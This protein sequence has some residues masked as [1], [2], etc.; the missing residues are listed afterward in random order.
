[1]H[2]RNI[3]ANFDFAQIFLDIIAIIFGY[4]ISVLIYNAFIKGYTVLQSQE[5]V[6][7][8]VVFAVIFVLSMLLLRMY[9]VTTFYY[10]DRIVKRT[11]TSAAIAGMNLSLIV[12]M[13]KIDNMSRL[14]FVMFCVISCMVV[15]TERIVLRLCKGKI[16]NGYTHILF[17]GDNDTLERYVSFVDK[18]AIKMKIDRFVNYNDP[19]LQTPE[20][21][22]SLLMEISIDEVQFVHAL[23]GNSKPNNIR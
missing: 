17:I 23:D 20:A 2:R 11:M 21:F 9:N 16:G 13:A 1:M 22:S 6:W 10:W 4:Y 7:A 12:F 14:F 3:T 8:Y 18:T 5:W 19:S 15:L